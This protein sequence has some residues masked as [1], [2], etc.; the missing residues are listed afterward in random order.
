MNADIL[1]AHV[2]ASLLTVL[3]V[4]GPVL[5]AAVVVGLLVGLGQALTQIQ[6]Q[7]LPQ[8]VKLMT[9]LIIIVLLGPVFSRQIS[10][11]ASRALDEFAAA[12]R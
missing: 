3:I 8:V 9:V 6:D 2:N 7:T 11:Q 12:T 4:S 5:V 10:V 1:L